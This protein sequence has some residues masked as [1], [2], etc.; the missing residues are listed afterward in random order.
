MGKSE[1]ITGQQGQA[2]P[3]PALVPASNSSEQA[4]KRQNGR[5]LVLHSQSFGAWERRVWVGWVPEKRDIIKRDTEGG[6]MRGVGT[7]NF[8]SDSEK[9]LGSSCISLT[10]L[11][12]TSWRF[13][14]LETA[15]T[16]DISLCPSF[17]YTGCSSAPELGSG[18]GVP[19]SGNS[20]WSLQGYL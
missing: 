19:I 16:T 11:G 6:L 17:S 18:H 4:K 13:F 14:T 8:R 2:P 12:T 9:E 3:S 15:R 7:G 5:C 10:N 1:S 20:S